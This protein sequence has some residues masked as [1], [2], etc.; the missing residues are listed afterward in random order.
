MPSESDRG[1]LSAESRHRF[2]LVA[3]VLGVVFFMAQFVLPMLVMLLFMM[4]MMIGHVFKDIDLDQAAV[5]HDE[6]WVI[7]RTIKTNWRKPESSE[8]TLALARVRLA[9]LADSGPALALE[10]ISADSDPALLSVGDRLWLIGSDTVAYFA[11]GSLTRL[12]GVK[13]PDRSSRPFAHE[14]QPA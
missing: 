12:P 11:N 7:E 1:Y 3:G 2:T 13:R 8:T 6:L 5:L 10:G 14:G 4:P 9:D